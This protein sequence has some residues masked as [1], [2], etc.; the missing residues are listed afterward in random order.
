MVSLRNKI[1]PTDSVQTLIACLDDDHGVNGNAFW[2]LRVSVEHEF[3]MDAA[4]RI[5]RYVKET[6]YRYYISGECRD[7]VIYDW[8]RWGIDR[9]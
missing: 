6:D 1:K 7:C 3:G 8:I 5:K 2:N 9:A 4:D